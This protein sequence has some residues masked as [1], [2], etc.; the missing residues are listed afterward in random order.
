MLVMVLCHNRRKTVQDPIIGPH[1]RME[2]K[3]HDRAN[4]LLYEW[5]DVVG[6]LDIERTQIDR[7]G[8]SGRKTTTAASTGQRFLYLEDRGS[9]KAKNRYSLPPVIEIPKDNPYD[10]LRNAIFEAIGHTKKEAA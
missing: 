3:L 9:F 8:A 2:P 5:A 10:P 6:Y 7:E 1:D 4:A